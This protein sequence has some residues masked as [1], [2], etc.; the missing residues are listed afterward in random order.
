MITIL[1]LFYLYQCD[2]EIIWLIQIAKFL[3]FKLCRAFDFD[4]GAPLLSGILNFSVENRGVQILAS[5]LG[6]EL[7][8]C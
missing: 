6:P 3:R 2:L 8:D 7:W 4:E 1:S 5:E